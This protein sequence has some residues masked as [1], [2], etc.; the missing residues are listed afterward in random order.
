MEKS[1]NI[2]VVPAEFDWSDLGSWDAIQ[3]VTN[4]DDND[5][6]SL[7]TK[8]LTEIN[9]TGNIVYANGKKVSLIDVHDLVIVSEG[10]HL[11][12]LPKNSSQKVKE[13]SKMNVD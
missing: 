6:I 7:A 8:K 5:N 1:E 11:M 9:S 2:I 3:D 4:S 13:I 10:E 12:I